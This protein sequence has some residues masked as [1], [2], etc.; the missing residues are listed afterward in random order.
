MTEFRNISPFC[1]HL[2]ANMPPDVA[3]SFTDAQ[4]SYVEQAIEN[5]PPRDHPVDI[6]L[7]IPLFSRRFYLVFLFGR[8]I[9]SPA[10]RERERARRLLWT[11][12]N[13]VTFALFLLLL[14]PTVIGAARL[15]LG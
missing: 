6:R 10:R 9:R 4:L 2:L 13:V 12:G 14:L 5:R 15:I 11:F 8:E 3:S 7:S 1:R